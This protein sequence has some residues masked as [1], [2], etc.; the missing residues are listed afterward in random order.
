M[1]RIPPVS[2]T[3]KHRVSPTKQSRLKLIKNQNTCQLTGVLFCM[4]KD[5]MLTIIGIRGKIIIENLTSQLPLS[6]T[7]VESE[8]KEPSPVFWRTIK[9]EYSDKQENSQKETDYR[10]YY[11]C[12]NCIDRCMYGSL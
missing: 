5:I 7:T 6:M 3:L 11:Y 1:Q 9:E 10:N 2:Y 12:D 8:H 4:F